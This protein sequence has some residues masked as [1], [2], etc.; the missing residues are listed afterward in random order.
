MNTLTKFIALKM[1]KINTLYIDITPLYDIIKV[2]SKGE[3]YCENLIRGKR[4]YGG[5]PW[6]MK[7]SG[8]SRKPHKI[9][10]F[11]GIDTK[12]DYL[13]LDNRVF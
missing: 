4:F 11:Q 12:H 13:F 3:I 7:K 5:N 6:E 10:L 1:T 2:S 9:R 8:K